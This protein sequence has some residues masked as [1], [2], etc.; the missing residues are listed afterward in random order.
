M[1]T[2][3]NFCSLVLLLTFVSIGAEARN[4]KGYY[5]FDLESV[6]CDSM[7]YKGINAAMEN[8]PDGC[9]S[10][11]CK[12]GNIN[13]RW[14]MQP[15]HFDLIVVNGGRAPIKILWDL[16]SVTMPS[17]NEIKITNNVK[18]Y[19][20][21]QQFIPTFVDRGGIYSGV[22]VPV[23]RIK[24]SFGID[25]KNNPESV[26][27][28]HGTENVVDQSYENVKKYNIAPLFGEYNKGTSDGKLIKTTLAVEVDGVV[29]VYDFN[30]KLSYNKQSVEMSPMSVFLLEYDINE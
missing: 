9:T 26:K 13:F 28:P 16:S 2:L 4:A 6:E 25:V 23:N 3:F 30:L 29:K 20:A 22:V 10:A 19:D 7:S 17:G 1:K 14:A 8:Q 15:T 27:T 21:T 5:S 18:Y 12:I 11:I 24:S